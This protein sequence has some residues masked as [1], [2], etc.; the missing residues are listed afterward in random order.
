MR[1]ILGVIEA[2]SFQTNL[3]ALN[4]A[5]EAA[6]AGEAGRGFAVVATEVRRLAQR[7]ADAASDISTLIEDSKS[8][9]ESGVAMVERAGSMLSEITEQTGTV[10]AQVSKVTR[11]AEEQ[12]IGLREIDAAITAMES[13]V[14]ST[15]SIAERT[16]RS[17]GELADQI[18]LVERNLSRFSITR[19]LDLDTGKAAKPV[20]SLPQ[21]VGANALAYE[22]DWS[23]L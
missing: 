14:Q 10:A 8:N 22:E 15:A 19:Q 5:V 3:L 17:M 4:A 21:T 9:M 11:T 2:I 23:D 1:E 12:T 18:A 7:S 13:S 20:T 6:R 16:T